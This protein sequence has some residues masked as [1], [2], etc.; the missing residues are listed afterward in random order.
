MREIILHYGNI[1]L[2]AIELLI[3]F[4][5]LRLSS[6]IN[7]SG[8]KKERG[9]FCLDR[10]NQKGDHPVMK[11]D[12]FDLDMEYRRHLV[13]FIT[14]NSVI[15]HSTKITIDGTSYLQKNLDGGTVFILGSADSKLHVQLPIPESVLKSLD[16]WCDVEMRLET[17]SGHRYKE[18][19]SL[20]F[21]KDSETA[22]YWQ[23][24]NHVLQIK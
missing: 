21:C 1:V 24:K 11:K 14:E 23:L 6:K 8:R 4:F 13:F 18:N 7:K 9:I 20:R 5:Q 2:L 19:V 16:F 12:D 10:W 15:L 22:T 17:L 3:L